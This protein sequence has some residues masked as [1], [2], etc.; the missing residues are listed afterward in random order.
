ME[1]QYTMNTDMNTFQNEIYFHFHFI[2]LIAGVIN[3]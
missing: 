3:N 1:A 2:Y